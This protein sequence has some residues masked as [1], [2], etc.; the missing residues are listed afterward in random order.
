MKFLVCFFEFWIRHMCID[1]RRRDRRMPEK[2]LD[3]ANISTIG[4]QGSSETMPQSM[5]MKIFENPCFYAIIFYHIRDKKSRQSYTIV[6]Q[7]A[8]CDIFYCK[9][10]PYEK[11]REI[12]ISHLEILHN[13]NFCII[14]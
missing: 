7:L 5:C 3:N 4:Q 6:N 13:S 12:I 14:G 10:M 8:R 1:L 9:I 11:G 2:F